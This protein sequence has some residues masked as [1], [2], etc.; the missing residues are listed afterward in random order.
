MHE[1]D[2]AKGGK[3]MQAKTLLLLCNT[4]H[5]GVQFFLPEHALG[6]SW[7]ILVDTSEKISEVVWKM[8]TDLPLK[9]RSVV[10]L[11][12]HDSKNDTVIIS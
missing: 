8:E 3:G 4:S 1:T 5:V 10:L 6:D 12:L 7:K 9:G 11:E 2:V